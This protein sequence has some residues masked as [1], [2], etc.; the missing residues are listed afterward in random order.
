MTYA[1][2]QTNIAAYLHRTDLT[3]R[4]PTFIGLA[5]AFLFRELDIKELQLTAALTTTGEYADLPVDFGSLSKLTA[6]ASGVTWTLDYQSAPEVFVS[7]T[8]APSQYA[9][10]N[11]QIRVIGA[12]TGQAVTLYYTPRIEPLSDSNTTNW[13]LD[14]A[15]DLYLYTSTLEAAK[16]IRDDAQAS[17]LA[18]LVPTLLDAVKR[19][20]VRRGQPTL[21]SLQIKVRR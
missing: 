20:S 8:A 19:Y 10:E 13:L 1:E 21:A 7:S 16:H 14:N 4:I 15:S 3:S 6:T 9:F 11:G 2:L 12:G 18:T 5:E 17:N